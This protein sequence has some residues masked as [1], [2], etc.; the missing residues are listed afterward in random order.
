MAAVANTAGW[1]WYHWLAAAVLLWR[2]RVVKMQESS[3]GTAGR[4]TGGQRRLNK[5]QLQIGVSDS[6]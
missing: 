6:A 5:E 3:T 1:R 4:L 2:R